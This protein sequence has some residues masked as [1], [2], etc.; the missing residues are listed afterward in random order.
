MLSIDQDQNIYALFSQF[1]LS[2]SGGEALGPS[3][4]P[5]LDSAGGLSF[6]DP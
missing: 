5:P 1:F 3:P 4:A 6:P 2:A